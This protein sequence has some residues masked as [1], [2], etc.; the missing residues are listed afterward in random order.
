MQLKVMVCCQVN[1]FGEGL[2]RLIEE[3]G[4]M[5]VIGVATC[6]QEMKSFLDFD[7]DVIITDMYSCR[8]VLKS[9]SPG[10][11]KK[12][13]LVNESMDI[14]SETLK[15]LITDGL[16]GILPKGA[17]IELLQKATRKLYEGEL[18]IDHQTMR[19]VFSSEPPTRAINITKKEVEVLNYIC[20]GMTNKEIAKKLFI[21]EQTVKSHCNHL[22][23]KFGVSSR[24]KLA[25]C[26]PKYFSSRL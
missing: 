6:D 9:L 25:L 2:K 3:K 22:F 14:S 7:P 4:D 5:K 12:V 20:N 1:L 23:K 17:N 26:A 21:S 8:K 19:E 16:G 24:L 10:G 15:S 18:W 13:L 11:D